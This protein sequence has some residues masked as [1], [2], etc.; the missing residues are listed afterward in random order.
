MRTIEPTQI[1]TREQIEW[2]KVYSEYSSAEWE[3]NYYSRGPGYGFNAEF[4]TEV[5]ADGD[6]FAI[7]IPG[8]KTEG[9]TC[10]GRFTWQ[11]WMVNASDPLHRVQVGAG[12]VKIAIGFTADST[13][14]VETRSTAQQ[15]VDSIDAA[16][17][18]FAT[19]D[20]TEYEITTPAGSRRVKRSD[21]ASMLEMR[22]MYATLVANEVARERVSNGGPVLQSI[23]VRMRSQ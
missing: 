11:A 17:L 2:T 12:H 6:G 18:A 19:S 21:K 5:T 14:A 10:A 7:V 9:I 13:A 15:I 3:L 1:T 4:G 20:V 23:K 8:A 16:M 22:K